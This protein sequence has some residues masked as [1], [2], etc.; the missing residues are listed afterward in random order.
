MRGKHCAVRC[1]GTLP[2]QK[3]ILRVR[4]YCQDSRWKKGIGNLV[5]AIASENGQTIPRQ[6]VPDAHRLVLGRA[7]HDVR[8]GGV[9]VPAMI[10]MQMIEMFKIPHMDAASS[11][12]IKKSNRE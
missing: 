4:R 10:G 6:N 8:V 2:I 5:T 11:I 12:R 9:P 1:A 3:T 7:G